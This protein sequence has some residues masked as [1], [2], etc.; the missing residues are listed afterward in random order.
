MAL[1]ADPGGNV[2][3]VVAKRSIPYRAAPFWSSPKMA[4]MRHSA[5][6]FR[7]YYAKAAD[8]C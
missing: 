8:F 3:F 4:D 2:G 5:A 1:C 6:H 7:K